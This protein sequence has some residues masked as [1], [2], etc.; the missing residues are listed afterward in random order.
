MYI[1]QVIRYAEATSSKCI[2]QDNSW[3]LERITEASSRTNLLRAGPGG[4]GSGSAG[5]AHVN[6]WKGKIVGLEAPWSFWSLIIFHDIKWCTFYFK[7]EEHFSIRIMCSIRICL[8]NVGKRVCDGGASLSS[9]RGVC[10]VG[11]AWRVRR[12]GGAWRVRRVGG[13]TRD[14]RPP[15]ARNTTRRYNV[16][17]TR[18]PRPARTSL[19]A[20][21]E[22]L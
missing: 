8:W 20:Q 4:R 15:V 18:K 21:L 3:W 10:C 1:C 16:A 14:L 12:V 7:I 6:G 22:T 9:V 17:E 13:G 2:Y 19:I 5:I 11:G